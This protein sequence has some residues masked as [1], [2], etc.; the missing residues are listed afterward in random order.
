MVCPAR[1]RNVDWLV[2]VVNY[3]V[4]RAWIEL[5]RWCKIAQF[6]DYL[7]ILHPVEFLVVRRE[8][9]R[10]AF[11]LSSSLECRGVC[12]AAIHSC[13]E[14]HVSDYGWTAAKVLVGALVAFGQCFGCLRCFNLVSLSVD[15]LEPPFDLNRDKSSPLQASRIEDTS[16]R[17]KLTNTLSAT[18]MHQRTNPIITFD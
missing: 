5:R 10:R 12:V 13:A 18:K 17:Q 4:I 2:V 16:P 8:R 15:L 1:V 7:A 6:N 9:A 11:I 14:K 3:D